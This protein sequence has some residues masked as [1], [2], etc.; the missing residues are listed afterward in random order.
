MVKTSITSENKIKPTKITI[1]M[2]IENAA[3]R[4]RRLFGKQART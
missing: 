2:T 3:N 4:Q 1:T